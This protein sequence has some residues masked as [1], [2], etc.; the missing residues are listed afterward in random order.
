MKR[1]R[2]GLFS[3]AVTLALVLFLLTNA[4]ESSQTA[5]SALQLAAAVVVPSLFPFCVLSFFLVLSGM[6]AKWGSFFRAG[7]WR[8]SSAWMEDV[9]QHGSSRPLRLPHRCGGSLRAL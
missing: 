1:R 6:A 2:G 7:L 4:A 5:L 3:L 8:E 9:R